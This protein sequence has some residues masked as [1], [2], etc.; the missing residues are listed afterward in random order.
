MRFR[1]STDER[2]RPV[3]KAIVYTSDEHHINSFDVDIEA[4]RIVGR[5]KQAGHESFI[6]GGAVRDLIVGKKPKDFD[7]VTSASPSQI[8]RLFR[9][10]RIIGRRFRLVHVYVGDTIYEVATFRSLRDGHNGNTYGTIEED[11]LRRDFTLNALF[12]D[13]KE[14]VVVDYVEGFKD[15]KTR[16]IRPIIP[17]SVMFK[18][19]PVRMLR[20]VKYAATTGFRLSLP[21]RWKIKQ[22]AHLLDT[23]S[24]SRRTEELFKI[25]NSGNSFAIVDQLL[26]F[27]LYQYLQP[28]A[29]SM[30]SSDAKFKN[31]YMQ[32]LLALDQL[33][34]C[35]K[36]LQSGE[37][38]SYFIRDY[39]N[40]IVDWKQEPFEAYRAALT[41]CRA[42]V[43]P[44][45][46]PRIELENAVRLL[47]REHGIGIKKARTFEKGRNK[48]AIPEPANEATQVPG[49]QGPK[50]RRRRRKNKPT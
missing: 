31:L 1:Y 43:L 27:S 24:P 37:V 9:N 44:M 49:S 3:K 18:D 30:M 14:Q 8:K 16:L 46:P 33:I 40:T 34:K 26:K 42:Y 17:L 13:P 38:I 47:F 21:L 41:A 48:E 19:D 2:G 7:I 4:V 22:Q 12:Y 11:V 5:L 39:L 35:G 15:I 28:N 36:E 23:V 25:I 20:A 10:A 32:S 50:K 29:V 6:V 45:N